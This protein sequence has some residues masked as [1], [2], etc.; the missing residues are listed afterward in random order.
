MTTIWG[1]TVH[2]RWKTVLLPAL[3]S[4]ASL[5]NVLF[6]DVPHELIRETLY[7]IRCSMCQVDWSLW[8]MRPFAHRSTCLSVPGTGFPKF[9][10]FPPGD[11]K[12]ILFSTALVFRFVR[13]WE[14]CL[15]SFRPRIPD[16]R[17]SRNRS[18]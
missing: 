6:V 17:L 3:P 11:G 4:L 12:P 1:D 14:L 8:R 18:C 9:L 7:P 13:E 16:K 2:C 5:M 15:Y 10:Q